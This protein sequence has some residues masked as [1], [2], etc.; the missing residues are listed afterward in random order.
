MNK[1]SENKNKLASN[2][3]GV[4]SDFLYRNILDQKRYIEVLKFVRG[5]RILDCACG[6]GW[7]SYVMAKAGAEQVVGLDLSSDAISSAKKYY[8]CDSIMYLEDNIY[9]F[10]SEQKF[11]VI[12]SFETLE[13][14]EDPLRFLNTL[15]NLS[16]TNSILFLSTPNGHCFKN[17]NELPYNPYHKTEFTKEEIFNLLETSKWSVEE[18]LGQH[19]MKKKSKEISVYRNF[20]KKF[21]KDKLRS[22]TYGIIYSMVGK[23]YRRLLNQK[24]FDPAHLSDCSPK[25]I[26]EDFEPAYHY[27]K[28]KLK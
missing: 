8:N 2:K 17:K 6:V 14:V 15:A 1:Y 10:N 23:I 12:T 26:T 3:S 5:K 11:D 24:M 27:L 16:H 4:R 25:Q 28:L 18:Y 13:H 20:I 21:W 19:P 9:D 22:E 7:G